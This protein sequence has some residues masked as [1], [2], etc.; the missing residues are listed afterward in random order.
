MRQTDI[1]TQ[2]DNGFHAYRIPS[3]IVTQKGTILA[4]AEARKN[5]RRDHGHLETVLRRS[6]DGGKTWRPIQV[7]AKDG[8]HAVQNP[9]AVIDRSVGTIWLMLIRTDAIRFKTEDDIEKSPTRARSVWVTHSTDEGTSW[10]KPAD[11]TESVCPGNWRECVPGPGVGIQLR[12]GRLVIP[13]Y[14]SVIGN[15]EGYQNYVIYS[16]DHGKTWRGGESTE[17]KM[18]ESQVVEL[19]DGSLMLNMRSNR[20]KGRR[21]IAVSKDGGK[22]WSKVSDDPTLIEPVCQASFIRYTDPSRSLR[23][24]LL[25]SNPAREERGDRTKLTVRISYDEGKTWPAAKLL[26]AGPSGYSCLAVLPDLSIG[27]L[28]ERGEKIYSEKITFARFSLDWLTD[29]KDSPQKRPP[30]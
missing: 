22:T 2:G 11:I 10:S 13:A 17:P 14:H 6:F 20:G 21:G 23:S 19:A 7:V 12:S 30:K 24:R 15:E 18:D 4:F 16:D 8:T 29:G 5:S 3:L 27:C 1:F 25:F 26:N 28:Y 9:T